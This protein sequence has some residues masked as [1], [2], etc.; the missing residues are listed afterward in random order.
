MTLDVTIPDVADYDI[1]K[2]TKFK[3]ETGENEY[4]IKT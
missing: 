1:W 4:L 3:D 2:D